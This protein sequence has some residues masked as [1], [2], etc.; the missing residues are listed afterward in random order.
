LIF[1]RRAGESLPLE[2]EEATIEVVEV[3]LVEEEERLVEEEEV[4]VETVLSAVKSSGNDVTLV[5]QHPMSKTGLVSSTFC[6]IVRVVQ[7]KP[8]GL[9]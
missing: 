1:A 6:R 3:E 2:E 5:V 4:V 8:G 9:Q 7:K